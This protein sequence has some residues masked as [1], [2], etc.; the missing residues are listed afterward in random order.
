[1]AAAAI[2]DSDIFMKK[3]GWPRSLFERVRSKIDEST[4]KTLTGK[5]LHVFLVGTCLHSLQN[6]HA[7][8]FI[9][10]SE[11]KMAATA[12]LDS[13]IFMKKSGWPRS[14]FE[15]VRSKIDES[16]EKT[17]TGKKLHVFLVGTCL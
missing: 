14:L 15:R 11:S 9:N 7:D 5:K 10:I 16:T 12:I 2:L 1:M 17:L 3:S 8:F 13:D 4:E 6:S